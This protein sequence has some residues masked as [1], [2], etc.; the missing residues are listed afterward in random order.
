MLF[1][2]SDVSVIV[3]SVFKTVVF[4]TL[5]FNIDETGCMTVQQSG[6]V[7][8]PTGAKQVGALASAERG[9]TVTLCCAV[10]AADQSLPPM[11]VFPR[12]HFQDNYS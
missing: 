4:L 2:T 10:N 6:K 5:I 9:Q 3:T 12:V 7:V 8:A 1:S 11:F